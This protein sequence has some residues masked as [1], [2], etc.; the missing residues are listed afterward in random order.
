MRQELR[1]IGPPGEFLDIERVEHPKLFLV[2]VSLAP[3]CRSIE[4]HCV[5]LDPS[6]SWIPG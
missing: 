2:W 1:L 6:Q 4:V 3:V 5:L